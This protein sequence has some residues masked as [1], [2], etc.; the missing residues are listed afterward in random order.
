MK[1]DNRVTN[2]DLRQ[3]W[4]GCAALLDG[5][6]IFIVDI[7]KA[8]HLLQI[9]FKDM[10]T[11]KLNVEVVD[12]E[13]LTAPDSRLGFM[14]SNGLAAFLQRRPVRKY[15]MGISDGN[16]RIEYLPRFNYNRNVHLFSIQSPEFADMLQGNYPSFDDAYEMTK[17]FGGLV[18]FDRQFAL[19]E[20]RNV[21][22][23][24]HPVG[25]LPRD[26]RKVQDIQ[27][28][29][30]FSFLKS[31]IGGFDREQAVRCIRG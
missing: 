5:S 13:K 11:L 25:L 24:E 28:E 23:K 26:S 27:F 30:K 4:R 12:P 16:F 2:E 22:Y 14:N 15:M 6:P 3:Y 9:R 29:N 19:D 31:V 1:L 21:W 7:A 18:A 20:D 17:A 10:R 8:D